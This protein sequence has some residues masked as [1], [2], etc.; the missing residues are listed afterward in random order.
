[1]NT[2]KSRSLGKNKCLQILEPQHLVSKHIY[3][4]YLRT[5]PYLRRQIRVFKGYVRYICASFFKS[6]REHLSN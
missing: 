4:I 6:K 2:L 3:I 5:P 1:M